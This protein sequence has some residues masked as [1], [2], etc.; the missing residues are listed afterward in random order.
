MQVLPTVPFKQRQVRLE[1]D[2]DREQK[3]LVEWFSE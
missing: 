2:I 3:E 1:E